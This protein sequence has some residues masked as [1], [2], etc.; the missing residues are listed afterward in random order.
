MQ[1]QLRDPPPG[2]AVPLPMRRNALHIHRRARW[3]DLVEHRRWCEMT[4][5]RAFRRAARPAKVSALTLNR[6]PSAPSR[7]TR[8]ATGAVSVLMT[9][10]SARPWNADAAKIDDAG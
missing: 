9:E 1:A 7:C 6:R 8:P 5:R 2:V 3:R 10:T 4:R